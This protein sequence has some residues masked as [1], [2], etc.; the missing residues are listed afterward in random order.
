MNTIDDCRN[1]K[2][3]WNGYGAEPIPEEVCDNAE[4]FAKLFV[5]ARNLEIFPTGEE[6]IQ[7]EFEA[8]DC[9]FEIE[10]FEDHCTY[11]FCKKYE[12]GIW[13]PVFKQ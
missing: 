6:S 11:L 7:L 4:K 13:Q 9:Y 1:L 2:K 10:V 12:N 3:D 8:L 5:G